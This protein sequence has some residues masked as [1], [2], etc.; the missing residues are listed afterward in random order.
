MAINPE[1]KCFAETIHELS[2]QPAPDLT[3][4]SR[5]ITHSFRRAGDDFQVVRTIIDGNRT[6]E[7]SMPLGEW[8]EEV[9]A[10]MPPPRLPKNLKPSAFGEIK[11]LVRFSVIVEE[12]PEFFNAF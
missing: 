5:I 1:A 8:S 3:G 10:T 9:Y 4:E 7:E 2:G 12:D 6:I 11:R